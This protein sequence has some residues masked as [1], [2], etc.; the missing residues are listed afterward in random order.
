[1][2]RVVFR[3]C[4]SAKS[5]R[6]M[7]EEE[8]PAETSVENKVVEESVPQSVA[9]QVEEPLEALTEV[10]APPVVEPIDFKND[11]LIKEALERFNASI[12]QTGVSKTP[13]NS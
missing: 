4:D 1:R 3:T 5:Q 6:Q 11:P 8:Q 2:C 13:K 9:P 10:S 12:V 7:L